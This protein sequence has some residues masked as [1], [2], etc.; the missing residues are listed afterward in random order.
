MRSLIDR[1][2]RGVS[3][4]ARCDSGLSD[5]LTEFSL[6]D[7]Y[8]LDHPGRKMWTWIGNSPT[9][10][11]RSYLDRVLVRR[12]NIDLSTCPTFHW[13]G[14]TDHKLIRVSLWLVNRPSLASYWKFNTSLLEIWDFRVRL[15]NQIQQALVRAVIGNKWWASLKYRIRDFAIK[16]SQ[17]LA[18]N[19]AKKAKSFRR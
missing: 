3:G 19:R 8:R 4:L 9:G 5:F 2:G 11:V 17:H 12:A 13:L 7:R 10:Q 18:L 16:Y 15:E 6:V 1:A 14:W